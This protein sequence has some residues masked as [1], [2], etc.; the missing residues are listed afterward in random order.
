MQKIVFNNS[1][2]LFSAVAAR[3]IISL[4]DIQNKSKNAAILLAGGSSILK[5]YKELLNLHPAYLSVNWFNVNFWWTDERFVEKDSSQNTYFQAYNSFLKNISFDPVKIHRILPQSQ[6]VSLKQSVSNY[7][8]LL[9]SEAIKEGSS[10]LLPKFDIVI[11]G[12]GEDTH[13]ASIFPKF[14]NQC[15]HSDELV[16]PIKHSP[17]SPSTRISLTIKALNSG[18][19]IWLIASGKNKKSAVSSCLSHKNRELSLYD[20]PASKIRGKLET[21]WF[22]DKESYN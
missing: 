11:L 9:K 3:L 21:I 4:N 12:V 20:K 22:L 2:I 6:S 13:I 7:K 18:Q 19:K 1:E 15:L 14:L 8:F 17:K 16:L 5:L 10:S